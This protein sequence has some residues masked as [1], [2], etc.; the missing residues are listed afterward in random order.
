MPLFPLSRGETVYKSLQIGSRLHSL[1]KDVSMCVYIYIK[2]GNYEQ[3]RAGTAT[4]SLKN[5]AKSRYKNLILNKQEKQKL[6]DLIEAWIHQLW[7]LIRKNKN[8]AQ[9][10]PRLQEQWRVGTFF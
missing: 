9:K 2:G 6:E 1:Q 10:F 7:K 8:R 4:D 3:N 5:N